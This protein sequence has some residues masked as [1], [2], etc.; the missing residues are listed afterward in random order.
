MLQ[1]IVG[2]SLATL[3]GIDPLIGLI[4]GSITLTGR[5]WYSRCVGEILETQYG[6][7]GASWHWAWQVRP[8]V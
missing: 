6:I 7:Q 5:S 2:I 4:A 1:N 8:L 3:L